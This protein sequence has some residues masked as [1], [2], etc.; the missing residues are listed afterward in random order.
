[1]SRVFINTRIY[2]RNVRRADSP[3]KAAH[4]FPLSALFAVCERLRQ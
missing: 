3:Q 1:L 2:I 4:G